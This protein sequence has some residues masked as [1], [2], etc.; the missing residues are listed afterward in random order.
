MVLTFDSIR[1]FSSNALV[2]LVRNLLHILISYK[3][4]AAMEICR[5]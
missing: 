5:L 2:E 1:I 4:A 3:S